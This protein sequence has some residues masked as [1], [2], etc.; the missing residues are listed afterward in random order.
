MVAVIITEVI[1]FSALSSCIYKSQAKSL[2]LLAKR[3]T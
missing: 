1:H 2:G 3:P